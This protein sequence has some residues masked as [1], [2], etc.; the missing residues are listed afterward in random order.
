MK[1]FYFKDIFQRLSTYVSN[2]RNFMSRDSN[3]LI[4]ALVFK[5]WI[6][7]CSSKVIWSDS[8]VMGVGA[9]TAKKVAKSTPPCSM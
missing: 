2:I 9:G 3:T 8:K 6:V 7:A 1:N 4:R 5:Y